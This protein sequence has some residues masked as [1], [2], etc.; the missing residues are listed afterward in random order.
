MNPQNHTQ[1]LKQI[2]VFFSAVGVIL[3][4]SVPVE[5]QLYNHTLTNFV[6]MAQIPATTSLDIV[7]T[8]VSAGEFTILTQALQAAD[9]VDILK[10]E[11]PFTIFA[12]TDKAFSELPPGTLENLLKPENK[13]EL[14][15]ILTYHVVPGK[16]L[17]TDLKSGEV[18]TVEGD[19]IN[20]Q[21]GASVKIDN[22]TVIKADVPASNGVIHVIDTVIKPN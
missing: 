5:A 2:T 15:K 22:A 6:N 13:A 18:E 3:G 7:D 14:V 21:V 9:L 19:T 8:V 12:P 1:K 4:G 16:V 11:G 20:V 17:S 10:A